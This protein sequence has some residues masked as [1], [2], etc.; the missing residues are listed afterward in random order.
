MEML[1]WQDLE[2]RL[3]SHLKDQPAER[4]RPAAWL[5]ERIGVRVQ[6][7]SN[8]WNRGTVPADQWLPIADVLGCSL[9]EMLGR[10]TPCAW[11]L[12]DVSAERWAALSERHKGVAEAAMLEAIERLDGQSR[13]QA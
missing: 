5:A 13:K 10:Q 6:A 12:E 4:D 8:W 11:P 7:V 9:D 1:K 3:Q 2:K